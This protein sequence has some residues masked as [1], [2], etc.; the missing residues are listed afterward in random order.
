[1]NESF[2]LVVVGTLM[3]SIISRSVN[4]AV[5]NENREVDIPR[6]P[7]GCSDWRTIRRN[8]VLYI[9]KTQYLKALLDSSSKAAFI[10]RPRRFGKSLFLQ[11]MKNFFEGRKEMFHGLFISEYGNAEFLKRDILECGTH[12]SS[13]WMK[14]PVI[15]LNFGLLAG[16]N[17]RREFKTH[18]AQMLRLEAYG[19]NVNFTRRENKISSLIKL[20]YNEKKMPVILLIDE[21]DKTYQDALVY[22][23]E[24][25]AAEVREELE[26]IYT[27]VKSCEDQLGLAFMIGISKLPISILECGANNFID[28]SYDTRFA[29]AFG[30]TEEEIRI[31][32]KKHLE[33]FAKVK[34]FTSNKTKDPV[35]IT[36]SKLLEHYNGHCFDKEGCNQSSHVL[37]PISTLETLINN[38]FNN[39][40]YQTCTAQ[41]I[42]RVFYKCS[43]KWHVN[44]FIKG[45][46]IQASQLTAR[47]YNQLLFANFP[48]YLFTF[49][50]VTIHKYDK[51][52]DEFTLTYT[53]KEIKDSIQ[54]EVIEYIPPEHSSFNT[55]WEERRTF[56]E[57]MDNGDF[58]TFIKALKRYDFI[59]FQYPSSD[60]VIAQEITR[61]FSRVL[62]R[63]P[64]AFK[65]DVTFTED[66]NQEKHA[67]NIDFLTTS[68]Q[69]DILISIKCS[70]STDG[71]ALNALNQLVGYYNNHPKNLMKAVQDLDVETDNLYFMGIGFTLSHKAEISEWIVLPLKNYT[72]DYTSIQAY[73]EEHFKNLTSIVSSNK[74][75]RI[76]T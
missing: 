4:L 1:M 5:V 9:D 23:E 22:E 66:K 68:L 31:N 56:M 44:D 35:D 28:L 39:Y 65:E 57:K 26:N 53:N 72:L 63:I 69:I 14:F 42:Q 3:F 40:W 67:G 70:N 52:K 32:M 34:H 6:L 43:E 10:T 12:I 17:T 64:I 74:N 61:R 45:Y 24:K 51:E 55:R 49:G 48:I 18:Y 8:N 36:L 38:R 19:N 15:Y 25:F 30:F 21:Y 59:P 60:E 50:Y 54:D 20:L 7:A 76:S 16:C 71:N 73:P 75:D 47:C 27:E 13:P 11:M 2:F 33:K 37:N 58:K 41:H 46:S 62:R 29:R